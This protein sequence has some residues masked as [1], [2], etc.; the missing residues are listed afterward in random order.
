MS[1]LLHFSG[2]GELPGKSKPSRFVGY[3]IPVGLAIQARQYFFSAFSPLGRP[4][5]HASH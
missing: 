5:L 2:L 4:L 3:T 1:P